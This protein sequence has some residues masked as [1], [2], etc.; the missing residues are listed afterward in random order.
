MD[1]N[2]SL[3]VPEGPRDLADA[4]TEFSVRDFGLRLKCLED[5]TIGATGVAGGWRFNPPLNMQMSGG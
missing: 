1:E 4:K 3:T 2:P 5:C